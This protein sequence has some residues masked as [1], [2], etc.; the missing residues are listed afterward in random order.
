M[1]LKI[2]WFTDWAHIA[3]SFHVSALDLAIHPACV[4]FPAPV[5]MAN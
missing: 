5:P 3:Q 1:E 4:L 2:D